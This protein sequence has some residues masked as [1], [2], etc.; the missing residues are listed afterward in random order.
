MTLAGLVNMSMVIMA[1]GLFHATGLT[2]IDTIEGAYEGLEDLVSGQAATIFGIALLASG[3]ASTSVGTMAGQV[4]MQ[5]FID[6]T[7]PL[8]L[9]RAITMAPALRDP[10]ARRRPDRRAGHQPGRALV[11]DPVR[12]DPAGGHRPP[13]RLM[14]ALVN[15]RWVTAV[16]AVVAALII[17]LNV[18]LLQQLFFG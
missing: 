15:P 1:A 18:F 11:R 8:L 2:G 17:S 5:G 16:A 12:A 14:G 7:I 4:V 3:L 9:R 6:R 10:G 13:A